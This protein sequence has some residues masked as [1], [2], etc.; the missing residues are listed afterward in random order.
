MEQ[1]VALLAERQHVVIGT[2]A[3]EQIG[4]Q[5]AAGKSFR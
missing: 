5:A 1:M 3:V 4:K 2:A